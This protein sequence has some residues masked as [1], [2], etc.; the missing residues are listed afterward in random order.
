MRNFKVEVGVPLLRTDL[1]NIPAQYRVRLEKLEV[2]GAIR[3]AVEKVERW[4]GVAWG[5]GGQR[6]RRT[7]K[8][9]NQG[10]SRGRTILQRLGM[11]KKDVE[12][13]GKI[14]EVRRIAVRE[15]LH[16]APPMKYQ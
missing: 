4:I 11:M 16:V 15:G 7:A 1:E 10:N 2:A 6:R 3:K 8:G 12:H 14:G 5:E 13:L 9:M